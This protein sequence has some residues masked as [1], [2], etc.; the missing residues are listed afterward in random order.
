MRARYAV[1]HHR[2]VKRL[3]KRTKGFWGGRNNLLR[4]AKDTVLR[5]ENFATRDRS[6]RKREFRSLWIARINA[7]A[8]DHGLRYGQ[9]IDGLTK[10]GVVINR[11][12]LS[13]LAIHDA[14]AFSKIVEAA[15]EQLNL[16]KA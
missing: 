16:I 4:V 13:E 12:M 6:V 15:R 1:A 7:A 8:R 2:A 3:H 14:A 9:L 11:K 10:A 5:A